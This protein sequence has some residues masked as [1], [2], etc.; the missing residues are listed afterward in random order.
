MLFSDCVRKVS[1]NCFINVLVRFP[2]GYVA[3]SPASLN[4]VITKEPEKVFD[5]GRHQLGM[6]TSSRKS[7]VELQETKILEASNYDMDV[8][9]VVQWRLLWYSAP[10]S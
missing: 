9:R 3:V 5:Y 4:L 1:S 7:Q 8:P 2:C 6:Y 10:S